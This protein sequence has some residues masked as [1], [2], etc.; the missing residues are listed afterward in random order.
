M[1]A[2]TVDRL[3]ELAIATRNRDKLREI[4]HAL[5]GLPINLLE[6][7]ANYPP[8]EETGTT[9]EEN[10]LAKA[11]AL[12]LAMGIPALA[13]DS[14][15]FVD[16]LGGLPGV[17]SSRYA[18]EN[19]TYTDN[20]N[21]LLATMQSVEER[22]AKFVCI[23]ALVW[24]HGRFE[25]VRGECSGL[26]TT[27]PHGSAGFGYDPVFLI[28]ELDRTFAQMTLA[29]KERLSHRGKALAMLRERLKR[30]MPVQPL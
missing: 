4:T 21:K 28:L 16:A 25:L 29:E 18:G 23:M 11:R 15:L 6:P 24:P 17:H 27:E 1:A 26:I 9:C 3:T 19:A 20:V 2:T 13:D 14:G 10:A 12:A 8:P 30:Y 7:P 22:N 5:T